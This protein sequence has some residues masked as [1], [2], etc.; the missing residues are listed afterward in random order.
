M[1]RKPQSSTSRPLRRSVATG[2]ILALLTFGA[3]AAWVQTQHQT[4]TAEAAL[5][6]LPRANLDDATSAAFFE[7]LSRGQIVGTFAEVANNPTFQKQSIDRLNLPHEQKVAIETTVTVVPDTSV[8]L[9]RVSAPTATVAE[10]VADTTAELAAAYLAG[11]TSA[12]R[13]QIIHPAQGSAA[14]S[15]MSPSLLLVLSGVV[16]LTVGVASQQAVYHLLLARRM[17]SPG[18]DPGALEP[19]ATPVEQ[20]SRAG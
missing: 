3:G 13:I 4:F 10:Q 1:M 7:T 17:A 14:S 20:L 18:E 19:L 12:Y 2:V 11:V 6:V 5:V 8:I 9:V 16:A 15:G